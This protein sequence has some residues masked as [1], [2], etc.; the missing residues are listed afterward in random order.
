MAGWVS[1]QAAFDSVTGA[2]ILQVLLDKA[3]DHPWREDEAGKSSSADFDGRHALNPGLVRANQVGGDFNGFEFEV[4]GVG[5]DLF[6]SA[7]YEQT[8]RAEDG[9]VKFDFHVIVHQGQ[10]ISDKPG[11]VSV[12]QCRRC[13][14]EACRYTYGM[15][16]LMTKQMWCC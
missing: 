14:K 7:A 9:A 4:R 8:A 1:S 12:Q 10:P 6:E 11:T 5:H 16:R 3:A 15:R 13:A 2:C